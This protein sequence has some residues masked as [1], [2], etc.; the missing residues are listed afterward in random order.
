[1]PGTSSASLLEEARELWQKLVLRG[2]VEGGARTGVQRPLHATATL[3]ADR[4]SPLARVAFDLLLVLEDPAAA[5]HNL[6]YARRL[7]ETSKNFMAR[8]TR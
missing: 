1:V 5:A 3:G 4:R 8:A 6:P 2:V 7:V